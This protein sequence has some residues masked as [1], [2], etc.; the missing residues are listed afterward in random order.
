MTNCNDLVIH[1]PLTTQVWIWVW[2]EP[3]A[4]KTKKKL[5]TASCII[6]LQVLREYFVAEALT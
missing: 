2:T 3:R 4:R 5:V 6:Y 1:G